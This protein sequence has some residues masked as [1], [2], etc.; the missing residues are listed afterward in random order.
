M[1]L[2]YLA[3]TVLFT[4]DIAGQSFGQLRWTPTIVNHA[5]FFLPNSLGSAINIPNTSVILSPNY[6]GTFHKVVAGSA[7]S[8]HGKHDQIGIGTGFNNKAMM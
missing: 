5:I 4:K 8:N 1:D 7:Y 6:E 2:R 3:K